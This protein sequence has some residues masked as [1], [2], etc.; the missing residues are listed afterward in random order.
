[1]PAQGGGASTQSWD[2][3]IVGGGAI[4][5]ACAWHAQ[6]RGLDVCVL[7]RGEPAAASRHAAGMLAPAAEAD[8]GEEALLELGLDAAEAW[9][10]FAA[11]LELPYRR[12]GTLKV[13]LD[14]DEAAELRRLHGLH[15]ERGLGSEW[16]APSAC[17]ELEPGLG[18]CTAGA[19]FPHEAEVDPR[20]VVA[21]LRER[22]VVRDDEAVDGLWEGER[23]RGVRTRGGDELRA[24]AIVLASG[25]W[26]VEWLPP[27]ARPPVRPVKGQILR[28][29]GEPVC[30]RILR[31]ERVYLVPRAGGELVVG[32]TS[33]E[34]GFDTAV[35]AGAV[36]ELLREA[37]RLLPDVAEL[38][39]VEAGVGLR[40]GSPD[41]LPLVGPGGVAGL[42]LATGHYR[43]GI[44]LTPTTGAAVSAL[45]AG[46][47]PP[48]AWAR[49][50]P[51]RFAG[52][53]S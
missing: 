40:P 29:R 18:A 14:R 36:H 6:G 33:E 10:A 50:S 17:R 16:L 4:G 52:V 25:C 53:A 51:G 9:P 48:A 34:R 46:E 41:N 19:F 23:L 1:M 28:L 44:L 8:F 39:L 42:V 12:T 37:Y 21:A 35:T 5:L 20:A 15:E 38:E 3:I 2:A 32:A 31:A 30:E 7:D 45:L 13:A 49:L 26:S 24:G 47:E 43:N 22:V 27:H 11:E